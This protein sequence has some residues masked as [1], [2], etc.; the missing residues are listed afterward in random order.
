[1]SKSVPHLLEERPILVYPTLATLA[2]IN[3]A[4]ILQQLHF[5]LNSTK[6]AKS[7][8]HFMDERW[9]VYN[10]YDEWHEHFPWIAVGTIKRLFIELEEM[11]IVLSKQGVA[12]DGT[13]DPHDRRKW[14]AI[15]YEQWDGW[16]ERM[17]TKCDDGTSQ[18][19][20]MTSSQ[21][22]PMIIGSTYPTANPTPEDAQKSAR[23]PNPDYDAVEE[24]WGYTGSLNG[25]MQKMLKGNSTNAKFKAGNVSPPISAPDLIF[26]AAWYRQ[27]ELH[28]DPDLNMLEDRMKIA[29]S[30]AKWRK[31]GCPRA[32]SKEQPEISQR[33]ADTGEHWLDDVDEE[34]ERE[35]RRNA[36]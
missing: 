25:E 14:Y 16:V 6:E 33:Q 24:V 8:S 28:D 2:G 17:V 22:V 35:Q 21:N 3:K 31:L 23:K 12:P 30:I 13:L 20:P 36:Q 11:G 10:S 32:K 1:M 26:W 18:N 7:Q 9:W 5:L 27:T 15:A 19:V 29:S 4:V 34:A